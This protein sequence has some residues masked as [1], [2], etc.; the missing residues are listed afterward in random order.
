MERS[1]DERDEVS[2]AGRR[3]RSSRRPAGYASV[4]RHDAYL[5]AWL[6]ATPNGANGGFGTSNCLLSYFTAAYSN[7]RR[8]FN[9]PRVRLSTLEDGGLV[10]LSFTG[11]T[12]NRLSSHSILS[13]WTRRCRGRLALVLSMV[14]RAP[15]GLTIL[16]CLSLPESSPLFPHV[17][18]GPTNI[19]RPL[20]TASASPFLST[21]RSLVTSI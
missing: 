7:C 9:I 13:L 14:C 3:S 12:C 17:H 1:K 4:P 15:R 6:G 18:L 11:Y 2:T 19:S 8:Q 5:M 21:E 16:N 20:Q 10:A